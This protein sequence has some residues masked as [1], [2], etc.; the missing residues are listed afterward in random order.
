MFTKGGVATQLP[1]LFE[2][3]LGMLAPAN[4]DP[5]AIAGGKTNA[6][7]RRI[8]KFRQTLL[9][10]LL[11]ARVSLPGESKVEMLA[12]EG[13][14][15]LLQTGCR[16]GPSTPLFLALDLASETHERLI[17]SVGD[18][19]SHANDVVAVFFELSGPQMVARSG[20]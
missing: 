18:R 14:I 9:P 16:F 5:V 3:L 6:N 1:S 10:N 4:F 13:I 2:V 7:P 20:I 8:R 11:C 17:D 15:L 12:A 19:L